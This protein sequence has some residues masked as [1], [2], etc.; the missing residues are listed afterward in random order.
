MRC[1]WRGRLC[2][3]RISKQVM[4]MQ[5]IFNDDLEFASLVDAI[6]S[7]PRPVIS[8]VVRVQHAVLTIEWWCSDFIRAVHQLVCVNVLHPRVAPVENTRDWCGEKKSRLWT[9]LSISLRFTT[10]N[11]MLQNGWGEHVVTLIGIFYRH[12]S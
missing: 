6:A 1:D 3:M 12:K 11:K 2:G 4:T 7:R 8:S 10:I 5:G 9:T